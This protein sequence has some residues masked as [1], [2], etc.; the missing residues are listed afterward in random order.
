[1]GG[2]GEGGTRCFNKLVLRVCGCGSRTGSRDDIDDSR[3]LGNIGSANASKVRKCRINF[4]L[5]AAPGIDT[6]LNLVREF[7]RWTEAS[8]VAVGIALGN[9]EP[10]VQALGHQL[11]ARGMCCDHAC[12]NGAGGSC[13]ER[14]VTSTDLRGVSSTGS[15]GRYICGMMFMNGGRVCR[16]ACCRLW[17]RF[18][19]TANMVT[20]MLLA[21][22]AIEVDRMDVHSTLAE[23]AFLRKFELDSSCA[24]TLVVVYVS[25]LA[26]TESHLA[27]RAA[28]WHLVR[29]KDISV[30]RS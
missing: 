19:P 24:A 15:S 14:W 20:W 1:M 4:L 9:R 12:S 13:C 27:T 16:H 29:D 3:V 25:S 10:C 30:P 22:R 28:I 11:R 21:S 18:R 26:R 8:C 17:L 6:G 2:P 5:G 23:L 7:G